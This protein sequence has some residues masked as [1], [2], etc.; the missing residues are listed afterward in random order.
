MQIYNI[1]DLKVGLD[2]RTR[3]M[4]RAEKYLCDGFAG[5]PD[6]I[7]KTS[8]EEIKAIVKPEWTEEIKAYVYEGKLFYKELINNFNGMMI[9]SSAIVVDERAYLFSAP[10]GTGKSTHTSFWLKKFGDRAYILNDDK[11]AVRVLDDGVFAYGTP[12][13]GKSDISINKRVQVAGICF[14]ERDGENWIK[15]MPDSEKVINMYHSSIRKIDKD[16]AVKLFEI[17]GQ[18]IERVPIYKMGCTPTAE[19]A[20]LAYEAMRE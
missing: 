12:W 15:P 13:S 19:A 2:C 6:C 8:P 11:P 10:S 3:T 7:I 18:I 17:I 14:L 20:D 9:H 4:Q 1:A 16:S 5:T